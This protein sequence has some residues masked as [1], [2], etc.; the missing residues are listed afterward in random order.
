MRADRL[1]CGPAE[2]ECG[3]GGLECRQDEIE[4]WRQM[5]YIAGRLD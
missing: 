3:Q 1:E 5:N 4:H 2:M